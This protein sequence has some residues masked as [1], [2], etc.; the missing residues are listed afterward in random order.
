[1]NPDE[2]YIEL[3]SDGKRYILAE[4]LADKFFEDYKV[5]EKKTGKQWEG[6]EYE[7]LFNETS[8]EI[9]RRASSSRTCWRQLFYP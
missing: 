1:M 4:A 8:A 7:P 3:E 9:V 2:N 5:T 6:L